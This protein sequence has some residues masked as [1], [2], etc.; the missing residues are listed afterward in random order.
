MRKGMGKALDV[1][2]A[3]LKLETPYPIEGYLISLAIVDID[4]QL[5]E[6]IGEP[7]YCRKV[8]KG[9][10]HTGIQFIGAEKEIS[11]FTV[12]LVRLHNHRKQDS[13]SKYRQRMWHRAACPRELDRSFELKQKFSCIEWR[14]S[15]G[16]TREAQASPCQNEQSVLAEDN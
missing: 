6:I 1:S 4:E 7:L 15:Y 5:I 16:S 11:D 12:G 14:P 8:A 3:G 13:M 2:R 10:Y 9:V